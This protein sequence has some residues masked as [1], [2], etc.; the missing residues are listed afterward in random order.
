M[1]PSNVAWLLAYAVVL[2]LVIGGLIYGRSQ[3]LTVYGSREAQN[4]WDQW[5]GDAKKMATQPGPVKR[6]EPKSAEP[7]ALV[8]MRDYFAICLGLAVLLS[9]VLFGTFMFFIR[10]AIN[11]P[12][13][14]LPTADSRLPT[15]GP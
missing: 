4:D 10:G 1:K 15:P 8:L 12:G 2:A 3:A 11:T 5:R 14:R 6:R 9:S 7:P 13:P